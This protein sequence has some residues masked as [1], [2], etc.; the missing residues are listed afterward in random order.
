MSRVFINSHKVN[1]TPWI[2]LLFWGIV[3]VIFH[4]FVFFHIQNHFSLLMKGHNSKAI[5]LAMM[6]DNTMFL[7][8]I[9]SN[10]S[11]HSWLNCW[12]YLFW[13]RGE[14][15]WVITILFGLDSYII[16]TLL[17]ILEKKEIVVRLFVKIWPSSS[18]PSF[19]DIYTGAVSILSVKS[20]QDGSLFFVLEFVKGHW[21]F[22]EVW[23]YWGIFFQQPIFL[24]AFNSKFTQRISMLGWHFLF[25][26]YQ[27]KTFLAFCS[28]YL[29]FS[30]NS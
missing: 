7:F 2:L 5:V 20:N 29:L 11:V 1:P 4:C 16:V 27:Q 23:S 14:I 9:Q 19:L 26:S 22:V 6:V 21:V 18:S 8:F 12:V 25:H 15:D 10:I 17:S 3:Q 30:E 24:G 13:G 28:F